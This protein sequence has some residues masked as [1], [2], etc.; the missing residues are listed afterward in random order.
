M[1]R[2]YE[3]DFEGMVVQHGTLFELGTSIKPPPKNP[4]EICPEWELPKG[5]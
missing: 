5:L 4:N 2:K 3:K 1:K